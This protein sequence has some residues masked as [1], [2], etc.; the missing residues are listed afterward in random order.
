MDGD[1]IG[2]GQEFVEAYRLHPHFLDGF[3][4][5][6]GVVADNVHLHAAGPVG[7]Y[8]TNAADADNTQC[9]VEQFLTPELLLFPL[10]A[11]HGCGRL[12]NVAAEG[13]E[14]GHCMLGR[15]DHVAIR[16]IHYYNAPFTGRLDVHIVQTYAGPADNFE[17]VR[18]LYDLFAHLGATADHQAVIVLDDADQFLLGEA[19]VHLHLEARCLFQSFNA[20]FM[21]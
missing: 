18:G 13:H 16:G 12:R 7:N 17:P 20:P 3:R 9:F 4:R 15:S 8:P 6:I 11:L 14:H 10:V 2:P 19:G 1:T 21:K 5:D